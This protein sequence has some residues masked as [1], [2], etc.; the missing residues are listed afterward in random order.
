M[1]TTAD[2]KTSGGASNNGPDIKQLADREL[3]KASFPGEGR[4][5]F[6]IALEDKVHKEI[7][8]HAKENKQVEICGVVVGRWGKDDKGP[9]VAIT[10]SIRGEAATNKFA[11]VTFTHD[12]WSKIN[13][14]MDKS[15][16]NEKI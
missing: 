2:N 15:Y 5:D 13:A 6:R 8:K 16:P 3:P 9:F 7:Q 10:A 12:T 4:S 11:E 14:E 1:T